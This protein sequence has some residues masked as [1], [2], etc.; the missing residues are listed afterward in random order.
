MHALKASEKV[1][2]IIFVIKGLNVRSW[3]QPIPY[4]VSSVWRAGES[5]WP[6]QCWA[7]L[8]WAGWWLQTGSGSVE[9]QER[10]GGHCGQ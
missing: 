8:G 5:Q 10:R 6:M 9:T 1:V 3:W 2:P 7:G 4:V